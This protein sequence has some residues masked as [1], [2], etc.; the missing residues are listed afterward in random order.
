MAR[1]LIV[2]DE[3]SLRHTLGVFLRGVGHEVVEADDAE[4]AEQRL[5]QTPF[6]VVVTDIILPRVSGVELLQ[7]IQNVAPH[8]Q[9][10]MMTGDPTLETAIESLRAGAVDYLFKPIDK[11]SIIKV[12]S[13]ATR[14][15][16]LEDTRRK[17]E[18]EN[19]LHREHLEA[20]VK[21]RTGQ[22]ADSEARYRLLVEKLPIAVMLLDTQQRIIM[23]N[24]ACARL[25]KVNGVDELTGLPARDFIVPSDPAAN[26]N[27]FAELMQNGFIPP[28]EHV[29]RCADGSAVPVEASAVVVKNDA[30]QMLGILGIAQGISERKRTQ[31]EADAREAIWRIFLE[32]DSLESIY[33]LLAKE[34]TR[35]LGFEIAAVELYDSVREEMIFMGVSGMAGIPIGMRIPAKETLSGIV[36]Q[37]QQPVNYSHA[38]IHMGKVNER[39]RQLGVK[40]FICAPFQAASRIVGTLVVA[41]SASREDAVDWL[42]NLTSI[43]QSLSLEIRRRLALEALHASETKFRCYVEQVSEALLVC[44]A[45]GQILDINQHACIISG[46]SREELLKRNLGDLVDATSTEKAAAAIKLSAPGVSGTLLIKALRQGGTTFP[47]ETTYVSFELDGEYRFMALARDITERV[48]SEQERTRLFTAIEQ[49]GEAVVITDPQARILFVNPAFEKITGYTK[50]EALGKT[51]HLLASGQHNAAFYQ[52]MWQALHKDKIWRGRFINRNKQGGLFHEDT[53]ISAIRNP[54]GDVVNYVAVKRDVTR[55]VQMEAQL[56]QAQKLEAI[57]LLAGGVAHDFNNIMAAIMMQVGILREKPAHSVESQ[58]LLRD[59]GEEAY[60]AAILTRQL[61]MF[62]R[63]SVLNINPLNLNLVVIN[64]LKMLRRLINENIKISFEDDSL[65]MCV[66]ADVGMLE[67][68]IMN[69]VINAR[70]ALPKGG[71]IIIRTTLETFDKLEGEINTERRVGRFVCLAVSDN[72][73]GMD[74]DTLKRIFEP[75]FTTKEVGKGTG[76][77]LATVHGIVAQH[78]GW[79]E[80]SSRLEQGSTF[81][82][83]LPYLNQTPQHATKSLEYKLLRGKGEKILLVEDS[84]KLRQAT[85]EALQLLG[86][87]VFEAENGKEAFEIW[88]IQE[89]RLEVR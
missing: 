26:T 87:G 2:D 15:K 6:D 45:T 17:L 71:R 31:A 62:S 86:Y 65:M 44:D 7:R 58:N 24:P 9:V 66:E 80:V 22:L 38:Q 42:Q 32:T 81:R 74:E 47:T 35:R 13:N 11:P 33:Q 89:G 46:Y 10:V 84:M 27:R 29:H 82:V 72:G 30:G 19:R 41:D 40:T 23:G 16:Q 52:N 28:A 67:Q 21:E 48:E 60:R 61:L 73:I 59:I 3:I 49:A 83:F 12:V 88:Q 75:F 63:R 54:E 5:V 53:T 76:L 57:G 20:L 68:V 85:A 51:P 43:A 69:L 4:V 77:G 39:L 70:D 56:H 50:A 34:L 1:I 37:T 55:E 18:E 14:I 8:V 25:Y 64:L 78:K 36:A 79:I